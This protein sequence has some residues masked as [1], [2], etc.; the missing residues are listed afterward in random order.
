MALA[1]RLLIN[2]IVAIIIIRFIY[3]RY[4]ETSKYMFT[5]FMI[6]TVVFLLCYSL[7]QNELDIGLAIGLFAVFGI[8]RYRTHTIQIKEMTYLFVVI[9]VAII[10]ALSNDKVSSLEMILSN[11]FVILMLFVIENTYKKKTKL[12]PQEITLAYSDLFQHDKKQLLKETLEK[13]FNCHIEKIE[14]QKIDLISKTVKL[15]YYFKV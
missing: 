13:E 6:S 11:A 7:K 3:H 9:G 14:I 2:L 1:I 12:L 10:N 4:S 8:I 15:T 5:Y